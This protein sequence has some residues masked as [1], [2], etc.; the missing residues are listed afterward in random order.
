MLT[1][2]TTGTFRRLTV[3]VVAGPPA[4]VDILHASIPFTG[5]LVST[6]TDQDVDDIVQTV[7]DRFI[8]AQP[9][10][11]VHVYRRWEGD[12]YAGPDVVYEPL[13]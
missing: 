4:E 5:D 7:I 13:V 8:A 6:L 12:N 10:Y 2:P 11:A 3:D 9:T 1:A